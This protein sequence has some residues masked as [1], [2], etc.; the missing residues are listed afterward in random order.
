[1]LKKTKI[2]SFP[3]EKSSSAFTSVKWRQNKEGKAEN[4]VTFSN[5]VGQIQSFNINTR[6]KVMQIDEKI[7]DDPQINIIDYNED[8]SQLAVAGAYPSIRIYDIETKKLKTELSGRGGLI[9]GHSNRVFSAK[10]IKDQSILISSGWDQ[11]IIFWDLRTSEPFDSLSGSQIYG[12]GL[13]IKEGI[14]LT[15]NYRESNGIQLYFKK[16]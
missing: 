11:R 12:D 2:C 16:I 14:L 13:D 1:M 5:S 8:Y 9:P 15:S 6:K 7:E 10:F 4:V 3:F